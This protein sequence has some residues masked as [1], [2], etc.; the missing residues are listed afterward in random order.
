MTNQKRVLC[1]L[2]SRDG[3]YKS[4]IDEL[5]GAMPESGVWD[6]LSGIPH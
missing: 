4:V 1:I 5:E 3:K 2:E 6:M